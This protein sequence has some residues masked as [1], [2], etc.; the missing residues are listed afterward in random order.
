MAKEPQVCLECKKSFKRIKPVS[1][2]PECKNEVY[3]LHPNFKPPKMNDL[4]AWE[5]VAF[6]IHKGFN[7]S[8]WVKK[9]SANNRDIGLMYRPGY[10]KNL[11]EAKEFIKKWK[12]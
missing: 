10:P 9:K 8:G 4:A 2:C 5:L 1:K 12:P 7:F 3:T 6:L 11:K